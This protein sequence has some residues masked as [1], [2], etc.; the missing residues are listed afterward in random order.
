MSGVCAVYVDGAV[1]A[2]TFT[3]GV[4][5]LTETYRWSPLGSTETPAAPG[6]VSTVTGAADGS[7]PAGISSTFTVSR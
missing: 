7:A 2:Y 3:C 5:L 6:T 1:R 4:P